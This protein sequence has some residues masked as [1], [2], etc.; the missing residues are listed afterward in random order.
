MKS[1]GRY[2]SKYLVSFSALMAGLIVFNLLAFIWTFYSVVSR[3]YGGLSPQKMVEAASAASRP[4]G[5]AEEMAHRLRSNSIW[6]MFLSDTGHCLW[7]VALPSEVPKD[8]SLQDVAVFAKGYLHDYPVFVRS[9]EDGLLVLGYPRGSYMKITGN[10]YPMAAV[11]TG[12][13]FFFIML[14]VD[15]AALFLAY[16]FSRKKIIRMTEPIISSI[17]SLSDQ[18]PVSLSISGDLSEI[19]DSINHASRV[20]SRQKQARANW[21]SGVSHDIR[22]PLSIIM[23]YSGKIACDDAAGDAVRQQAEIIKCQS[24]RIKELV[25]DLNLVT[26]LEYDMQ[27]I[28]KEPVRLSRLLR[29]CAA[30]LLGTETSGYYPIEIL[31]PPSAETAILDCDARLVSRAVS[32]LVL[33]SIRHNPQGCRVTIKLDSAGDALLITVA[34]DGVGLSSEKLRELQERPHYMNSTD[35]RLDLRHGLG[36]ILVRQI[37]EAHG[38]S[39]RIESEESHGCRTILSFPGQ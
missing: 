29:S 20:L 36:L 35:E 13:M 31:I 9:R 4:D 3:D 33:N 27:P 17:I 25:Q 24:L 34:D 12:P 6:A 30:E 5:I 10:Y 15:L 37:M 21:I 11:R 16:C 23:G 19:A 18:K 7:S 32:N 22:T 8:Y 2:L 1:F 28:R 26:Q 14:A 39:M 38:G